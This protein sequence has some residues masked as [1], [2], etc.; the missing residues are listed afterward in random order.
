MKIWT[1]LRAFI[2]H[3]REPTGGL[4]HGN[5]SRGSIRG[6]QLLDL[7]NITSLGRNLLYGVK[8]YVTD[9]I[10]YISVWQHNPISSRWSLLSRFSV[11]S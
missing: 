4:K 5:E 2:Y 11:P 3:R 9:N 6:G 8:F 7:A 10:Y 1:V